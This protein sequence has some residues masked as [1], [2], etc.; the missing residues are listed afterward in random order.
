MTENRLRRI[1]RS[2]I[3]ESTN[4][5]MGEDMRTESNKVNVLFKELASYVKATQKNGALTLTRE[6]MTSPEKFILSYL[7]FLDSSEREAFRGYLQGD[8]LETFN[9]LNPDDYIEDSNG[10]LKKLQKNI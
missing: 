4:W 10:R 2:V 5:D 8:L 9:D 3:M 1:I 6:T 7:G